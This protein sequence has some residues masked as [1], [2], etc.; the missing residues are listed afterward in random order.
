MRAWVASLERL[1]GPERDRAG[2]PVPFPRERITPYAFS[3]SFAQRHA[4]AGTPVDVLRDLLG[5]D[6]VRTTLG[7]YRV[8]ATRKRAAQ[9]ALGSLQLDA[10]GRRSRPG[11]GALL[12]S[13]ALRDQIGQVAVPFGICTEPTNV[14]AGGQS[15]PFRHRCLGCSYFRTD[16]S[17]RPELRAYLGELLADRERLAAAV[18]ELAAWARSDA[19]P[20]EGEIAALRH[21]IGA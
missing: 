21:L 9:D 2:N 19:V 16:P 1:D 12:A 20:S 7:Y 13:E 18:P 8:T 15:C 4:D 5:H 10:A 17:Y 14:T 3:H 6:T 11:S